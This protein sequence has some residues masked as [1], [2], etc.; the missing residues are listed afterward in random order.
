MVTELALALRCTFL[1]V[2][3]VA[4]EYRH[5]TPCGWDVLY[6]FPFATKVKQTQHSRDAKR[7]I[8][9]IREI[10]FYVILNA[11]I[12]SVNALAGVL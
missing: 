9:F 2:T 8:R 10:T 1:I 4:F 5:A 6:F 7:Q 3:L 12:V 11:F